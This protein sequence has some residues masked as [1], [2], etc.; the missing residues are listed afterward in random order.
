MPYIICTRSVHSSA[1]IILFSHEYTCYRWGNSVK[2]IADLIG[3][4]GVRIYQYLD[5]I[6]AYAKR[7]YGEE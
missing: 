2:E 6:T 4:S 1:V 5:Q 7:Y 3:I